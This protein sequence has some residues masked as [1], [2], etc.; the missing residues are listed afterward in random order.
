MFGNQRELNTVPPTPPTSLFYVLMRCWDLCV[1]DIFYT[2]G[3]QRCRCPELVA[4]WKVLVKSSVKSLIPMR[5][6]HLLNERHNLH[7]LKGI[8]KKN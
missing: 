3:G 2:Q 6:Q 5:K 8:A 1:L 4:Y 7:R